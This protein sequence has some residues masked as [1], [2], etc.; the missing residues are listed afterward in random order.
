[1]PKADLFQPNHL[2]EEI[3]RRERLWK[4]RHERMDFW[5]QVYLL[6]D[7]YQENKP[8]GQRR[9]ISNEPMT[10]VDTSHRVISRF[11]IQWQ[12]AIDAQR[13]DMED[14]E[15]LYGDIER[16]LYGFMEDIDE[17][18][19]DRGE[20]IARK[21]V[22]Y[23]GLLRGMIASK[24]HVTTQAGRAS[25]IVH[26]NYDS[27]FVLPTWDS[28][29]LNSV[30]AKTPLI[31]AD[32][33][34]Q[35]PDTAP[36]GV[37]L[38][39]EMVKIEVWDKVQFAVGLQNHGD[40][41]ANSIHWL[42]PPTKHGFFG[43]DGKF[44]KG[45]INKLPFVIRDV[46]PL[47]ISEKPR[48]NYSSV[49]P[50]GANQVLPRNLRNM[51]NVSAG[52]TWRNTRRPIAERGRSILSSIERHVGQFNEAVATIWQ[53]FSLDT[54]GIY[55]MSTR[56]G[57]VPE[58]IGQALGTGGIVGMERGD[59]V[60]RFAPQPANPSGLQFMEI[61]QDE[62]QKGTIASVL[63]AL[64]EFRSGFLQARMEQVALNALEPWI[65]GQNSWASGVGQLI[66]DQISAG[67]MGTDK[68][69]LAFN[70][71]G[72]I[73]ARNF[74]VTEFD[75]ASLKDFRP[76]VKGEVEPSLPVDM[77]ERATIANLLANGRRPLLSRS[78]TQEKILR[79]PDP[80]RENDRIWEDVA[81]TDPVVIMEEIAQGLERRGNNEVA[82]IFRNREM[83]A[84]AIEMFQQMQVQQLVSGG[85]GLGGGAGQINQRGDV[86][87]EN[88]SG[89]PG[90]VSPEA[91]PPESR[92]EGRER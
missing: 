61:L 68:I 67:S 29:S 83:M 1:M 31:G 72:E 77:M 24:T 47:A 91:L 14:Q 41:K 15:R 54:F 23:Q 58:D 66:V 45:K 85:G 16:A 36:D 53:N 44:S 12:I 34:E 32:I 4:P 13:K 59:G 90:G 35:Y 70:K 73:G 79:I 48:A 21:Y 65:S 19:L 56:G 57:V 87:Q 11:P 49:N 92:F 17:G 88:P 63:Q 69:S 52:Q 75:P 5:M 86:S 6:Y 78:T 26:V 38:E 10:I 22:A 76:I 82:Q 9:F 7:A 81:E 62:R 33:V 25:N 8:L 27:R 89:R 50:Q 55:F 71:T 40:A 37:N 42:I 39:K 20:M 60:Q 28:D 3:V 64:G 30:I 74:F 43:D 2:S 46:N 51:S 84:L 80:Q 18:L